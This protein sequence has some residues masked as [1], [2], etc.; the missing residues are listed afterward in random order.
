MLCGSVST[1]ACSETESIPLK[2]EEEKGSQLK[3]LCECMSVN[4]VW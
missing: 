2:V 4:V 3:G 1:M